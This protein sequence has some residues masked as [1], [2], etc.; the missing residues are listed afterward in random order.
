MDLK[1]QRLRQENNI[2]HVKP[3]CSLTNQQAGQVDKFELLQGLSTVHGKV[4]LSKS[5]G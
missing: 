2:N 3:A 5:L 4:V 1:P